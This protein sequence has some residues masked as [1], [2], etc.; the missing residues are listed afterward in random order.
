[1]YFLAGPLTP[2]LDALAT[3]TGNFGIAIVLLTL[4]VRAIL[5]P[6]QSKQLKSTAKMRELQPKLKEIQDKYKD[7]PEEYQKRMMA[8]YKEH[9]VNPF[10]GCLPT[11][12]QLPVMF[13][14]YGVLLQFPTRLAE[15]PEMQAAISNVFLGMDMTERS[16]I[17][18]IF[19]GI[20]SLAMAFSMPGDPMQRRMMAP[21]S[22]MTLFIGLTLPAGL[23]LY[24]T[25]TNI[26]SAS[27]QYF[28]RTKT[29]APQKP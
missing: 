27:Q 13:G 22:L 7:K 19:A 17:L 23:V 9:N 28:L 12:I 2:V 29:T 18:G 24:I 5:F 6:F 3:W 20:T 8:L 25:I 4:L 1:M 26:V 15:N 11:L 10:G 16:I 21:L 14:L